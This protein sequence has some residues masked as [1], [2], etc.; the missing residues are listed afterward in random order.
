[1][2]KFRDLTGQ[3]FGKL[4]VLENT[5]KRDNNGVIL[6]YCIC[7][8]GKYIETR[9]YCLT[10]GHTKSCGCFNRQRS[11]EANT[12]KS[13]KNKLTKGTSSFNTL[14]RSYKRNAFQRG[15][16]FNLSK[17]D[18]RE[19]TSQ[20]CHYC[21]KSPAQ[22]F[23]VPNCNGRYIYNGLDRSDNSKSYT[24]DN[25]LPCCKH[26]NYAKHT[27]SVEEFKEHITAIYNNFV[28]PSLENLIQ[29]N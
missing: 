5:T 25:V 10:R 28:N 22:E 20:N 27:Q 2:G 12:G 15:Y 18:F 17:E 24:Y 4:T 14:Y 3:K 26:C 9:S 16:D 6:W 8:C 21:G 1:M 11:K 13:P 23:S 29:S 7:D 19:L